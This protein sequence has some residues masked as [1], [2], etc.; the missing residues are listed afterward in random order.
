MS[1]LTANRGDPVTDETEV[2]RRCYV[3]L[4]RFATVAAPPDVEPEDLLQDALV[5][6]L[7]T[8]PLAELDN[9]EA[10][11]R[12]MMLNQVSNH[13]RRTRI[14]WNAER[15]LK[16]SR[17]EPEPVYPS[18]LAELIWLGPRQRAVLYL[19]E[20]DQPSIGCRRNRDR[21]G[22]HRPALAAFG[23]AKRDPRSQ[24]GTPH[25]IC[26]VR[27]CRSSSAL[28]PSNRRRYRRCGAS[29]RR[30][31]QNRRTRP[32]SQSPCSSRSQRTS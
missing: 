8:R 31:T 30:H 16:A 29:T 23:R 11:L 15:L 32:R 10:Y 25:R 3:K 26:S 19:S 27:S 13:R 4:R 7:R 12:R 5:A 2:F 28:P 6:T 9:P 18:D 20:V 21:L 1:D 14:R 24:Y 22:R 17:T